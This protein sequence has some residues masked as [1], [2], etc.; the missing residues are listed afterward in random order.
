MSKCCKCWTKFLPHNWLC[1]KG[2]YVVF[3][4]LFYLTL[5]M[6][7]Y[8][9]ANLFAYF[10]QYNQG[11]LWATLTTGAMWG[12]LAV[13]WAQILGGAL[14]LLTV[15]KALKALRKVE[16]AV[17]PCCCQAGKETKEEAK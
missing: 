8:V 5:A 15:A 12:A 7:L 10:Y 2:L 3:I 4:V 16:H 14:V 9:G 13:A 17:A 1:L 11:A 6:A